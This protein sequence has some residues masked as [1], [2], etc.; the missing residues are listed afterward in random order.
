MQM[1]DFPNDKNT[2]SEQKLRKS[3]LRNRPFPLETKVF[4]ILTR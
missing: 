2:V 3:E 4:L 1:A